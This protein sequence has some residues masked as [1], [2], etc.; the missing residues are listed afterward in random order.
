MDTFEKEVAET[1]EWQSSTRF[2]GLNRLYSARQ[3]VEQRGNIQDDYTIAR[4]AAVALFAVVAWSS[5]WNDAPTYDEPYH[6]GAGVLQPM[7][8]GAA[9]FPTGTA[10]R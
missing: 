7:A 9:A 10:R 1:T 8:N 5:V 2:E 3:V 4:T 6:L